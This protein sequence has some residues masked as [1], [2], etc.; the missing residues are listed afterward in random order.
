[1][2]EQFHDPHLEVLQQL[3]VESQQELQYQVVEE[4]V[5]EQVE[6]VQV[7]SEV[8]YTKQEQ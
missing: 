3:E 2:V 8:V 6:Q 1:V 5:A 4:V 7:V